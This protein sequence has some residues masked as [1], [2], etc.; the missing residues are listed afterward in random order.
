MSGFKLIRE[1]QRTY[2]RLAPPVVVYTGRELSREEDTELRLISDSVVIKNARSPERLLDETALFLHRVQSRLPPTKRRILE[3]AQKTDAVLSGRSA[4]IVD[5]DVRNIFALTAVLEEV[6]M[7]VEYAESGH[8]ALERMAREPG[9]D[10]VLMDVMMPE[11]DG[12]EAIRQIRA[13]DRFKKLPV[14]SVTAKAM[15]GDRE[16]CLQAGASDYITKPVD[17][18]QL[19]SLLRVWLYA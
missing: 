18:E 16:K 9:F 19:R 6:G 8:A 7:R 1:I 14:I 15:K 13:Q 12:F 10:V 11:M 5:D 3:K 2:G 4:L 17:M